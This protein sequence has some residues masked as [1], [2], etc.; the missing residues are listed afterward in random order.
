MSRLES[1]SGS[2]AIIGAKGER[3]LKPTV[4]KALGEMMVETCEMGTAKSGF[5]DLKGRRFLGGAKVAGKTGSLSVNRPVYQGY[6][7]FV[8]YAPADRPTVVV[9]VLLAN[10]PKW[11]LKAHT[12]ARMVLQ[13]ALRITAKPEKSGNKDLL[14]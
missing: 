5:R 6:S 13:K 14:K 11:R 2:Q 1:P 7:W 9:A 4:A 8:G 12:A 10:P 3:V